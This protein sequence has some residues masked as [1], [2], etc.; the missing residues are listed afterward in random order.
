MKKILVINGHPD[1]ESFNHALSRAYIKGALKAGVDPD[2]INIADLSFDP[3]L[4]YGYRKVMDLEPDLEEAIGK[5]KKADH[6][7]WF[8]PMWWYGSP[9]LMKGFIDRTFLPGVAYKFEEGKTFPNKLFKGKT[10][11]AVITAD[12]PKWYDFLVMGKPAIKQFKKGTMEFCGIK[13]VKI[14]YFAPV[15][16]SKMEQR[17]KWIKQVTALGENLG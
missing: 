11:R 4:K 13:P 9:A 17:E 14:T 16:H 2:V 15:N 7:V 10:A 1:K 3:V 12:T 6:I 8:F 5:I